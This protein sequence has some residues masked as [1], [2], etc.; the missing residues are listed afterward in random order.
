MSQRSE[1][2]REVMGLRRKTSPEADER[3]LADVLAAF[4]EAQ[5]R[6]M[7]VRGRVAALAAVAAAVVLLAGILIGIGI[8]PRMP[9]GVTPPMVSPR[10]EVAVEEKPAREAPPT[11][12]IEHKPAA[13]RTAEQMFTER[14]IEGLLKMVGDKDRELDSKLTAA[15]YLAQIGELDTAEKLD[16]LGA[17]S[18]DKQLAVLLDAI[19]TQIR[20]RLGGATH[21]VEEAVVYAGVV[22]DE[23]GLGVENV[24][25]RSEILYRGRGQ[26]AKHE[27]DTVTDSAGRFEMALPQSGDKRLFVFDHPRYAFAWWQPSDISREARITLLE[28]RQ[29]AGRVIDDRGRAVADAGVLANIARDV[30]YPNMGKECFLRA[31][32]DSA[33][34]FVIERVFEDARLRISVVKQGYAAFMTA[35]YRDGE[36][37]VGAGDGGLAFALGP[38]GYIGGQ[39]VRKGAP[40]EKGGI[41]VDCNGPA[42]KAWGVT[43]PDGKFEI[44]GLAP[45]IVDVMVRDEDFARTGLACRP[46]LDVQVYRGTRSD[47][48]LEVAEAVR[49]TLEVVN[50]VTGEAVGGR[51]LKVRAVGAGTTDEIGQW[52]FNA[53]PGEY[54]FST[55]E[56]TGAGPE[57][58]EH[59]FEVSPGAAERLVEIAVAER[60]MIRGALVDEAGAPVEGSVYLGPAEG[61]TRGYGIFEIP[62]PNYVA[63]E[64]YVGYAFSADKKFGRAFLWNAGQKPGGLL[65]DVAPLASIVGRVVD[66][67]G[68]PIEDLAPKLG[69]V[70]PDGEMREAA[71]P[72]WET[73]LQGDGWFRIDGVPTGVAMAV[74]FRSLKEPTV[75]QIPPMR[76]ARVV[77]VG[78]IVLDWMGPAGTLAE[79]DGVLAGAVINERGQP[80]AEAKVTAAVGSRMFF[81]YTGLDGRF[82]VTGLPKAEKVSVSVRAI[83]Y[84][85]QSFEAVVDDRPIEVML[86]RERP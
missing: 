39:L 18:D 35:G 1:L 84:A 16:K 5:P 30:R 79:W 37:A 11:P 36:F 48:Q 76:Q 73:T 42:G 55:K 83:G 50:S 56:W 40:F 2:E 59:V 28:P 49:V 63:S 62:E 24:I 20:D 64:T 51:D 47:V 80:L 65:I 70:L 68:T 19:A 25:V 45:G 9:E 41:I 3:I 72:R 26:L 13:T 61:R 15:V 57:E 58:V 14:D 74:Y 33:G 71:R 43:D 7:T 78:Q 67:S 6:G 75:L 31:Q 60:P 23:A 81:D 38:G 52:R 34:R 53:A 32:T 77:E 27:A 46:L 86:L 8:A 29:V 4:Q 21:T 17:T 12:P 22:T 85:G 44:L 69:V 10:P 66:A 54:V 82:A